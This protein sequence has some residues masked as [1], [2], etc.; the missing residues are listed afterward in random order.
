M[1]CSFFSTPILVRIAPVASIAPGPS[2]LLPVARK[3]I[4]CDDDGVLKSI[5]LHIIHLNN[6]TN[7]PSQIQDITNMGDCKEYKLVPLS[8]EE[9]KL[10][11]KVIN[12]NHIKKSEL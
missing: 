7:K 9:Q 2:S 11:D 4:W 8:N 6:I 3:N 5:Q 1:T 12:C 10:L